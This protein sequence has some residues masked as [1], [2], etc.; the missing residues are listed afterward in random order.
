M[1]KSGAKPV[2]R[3]SVDLVKENVARLKE[4]FP[5]VVSEGKVDF[6]KLKAT[7]GEIVDDRPE[8]YSFTWA[9]KRDAIRLL[10]VPSR[11]ALKPCPEESV[12]WD[13]TKNLFIEG[14][15]LEVLKLLYKSY[16]GRV[17]M[18][19]IDP[20][21]N[22]GDD[23]IYR[24]DF[25]DPLAVYLELTSQKDAA[26]NLLTSNPERSGRYH[27]TWLSMI[28]PRVFVARQL[29]REDGFIVIS[30]D[31]A[32][33]G[34]LR[35]VMNELFGEENFVAVLTWDRNRKNDAKLFSVG[36]EYM[37]VY[38]KNRNFL[39]DSDVVLRAPKEGIDDV[40]REFDRLREEHADDW[41]M[42]RKGL[43]RFFD[44]MPDDDPRKSLARFSRVD[45]KGPYRD[46]GNPS[47]PGGGGPRYAVPHPKTNKPCKIPSRGWLWPTKKRFDEEYAAGHIVFGK[48]ETTVPSVRSNLFEKTTEVMR[49]V[50][51]SYAQTA[52]QE[53]DALFDGVRVF[54]N[55]KHYADL[56]QMVEY[57]T[58][59]DDLVCDFFAG[60]CS[61]THAVLH[62]NHECESSRRYLCVQLP[63]PVD[64]ST[65]AGRNALKL[66]LRTIAEIGKERIR[67]VVARMKKDMEG[68]LEFEGL[69]TSKDLGFRVFKLAESNYRRWRGTEEKDGQKYADAMALFTDSLLPGWK[70]QDLVWEVALKEGYSLSS[71]VEALSEVEAN[72]VFRVTDPERDQS[73]CICLDDKFNDETAKAMM[74]GKEDLFVC[75]DS[76]LTDEQA[77]NLALQCKL[78]TI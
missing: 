36:H 67:R 63:E 49:S 46:D 27:S 26:G 72:Q 7:L 3:Q 9:G 33:F 52:A 70:P 17:K 73:F 37:V 5:E 24:D 60:S 40:R 6:E 23:R 42:V 59:S 34:N 68:H 39:K 54:D 35:A 48:D 65:H 20:P 12:N 57:L 56:S 15:N 41:A 28:Y 11:A 66:G 45:A 22:T 31:D 32:E 44:A 38:A 78:K 29:L 25:S 62:T 14:E 64:D 76:A 47:W 30:I 21:Y 50:H 4:L 1:A 13:T 43:K 16:A 71:T 77:A 8:R 69:G 19:Y 75:R 61:L 58:E 51:Y 74:L 55:P 53:F 2:E 18:I 10:Q